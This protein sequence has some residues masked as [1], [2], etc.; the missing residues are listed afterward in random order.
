MPKTV[1]L[2]F[3]ED[4]VMWVASKLS[5]AVGALG[6]EAM[7]PHKWILFFGC[8][9]KEFRVVVASLVDWMSNSSSPWVHLLRTDCM[10]PRGNI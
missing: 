8:A 6:A 9:S 3:T 7:E 1:P 4:D 5:G 10:W 2:D